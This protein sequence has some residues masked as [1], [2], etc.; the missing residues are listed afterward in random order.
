MLTLSYHTMEIKT[1]VGNRGF[2]M[3]KKYRCLYNHIS[4]SIRNIFKWFAA[5]ERVFS[6]QSN[7]FFMT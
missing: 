1:K 2:L 6:L 7:Y 3:Y 4:N 5:F